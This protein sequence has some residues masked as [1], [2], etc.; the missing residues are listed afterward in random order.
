MGPVQGFR[1]VREMSLVSPR[2]VLGGCSYEDLR[3][4]EILGESVSC[5]EILWTGSQGFAVIQN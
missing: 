2:I 4:L 5:I 3:C 1:L